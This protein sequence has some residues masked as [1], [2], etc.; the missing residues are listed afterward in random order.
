MAALSIEQ[1]KTFVDRCPR[2]V[3]SYDAMR[4]SVDIEDTN[5][6]NLCDECNAYAIEEGHPGVVRLDER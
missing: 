3:Y 4:Q 2:K 6:C 1:K 5:K